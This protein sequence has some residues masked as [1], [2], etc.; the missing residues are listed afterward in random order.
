MKKVKK[1]RVSK[2]SIRP[3]KSVRPRKAAGKRGKPAVKKENI[4]LPVV[5]KEPSHDIPVNPADPSVKA[6]G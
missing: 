1:T 5:P 6:K 2:K 4:E 3:R